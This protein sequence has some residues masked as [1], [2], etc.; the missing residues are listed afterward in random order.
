MGESKI[1]FGDKIFL[2]G[3]FMENI[4][5]FDKISYNSIMGYM[6][7]GGYYVTA[8]ETDNPIAS[9]PGFVVDISYTPDLA[10]ATPFSQMEV[11]DVTERLALS[12]P[13]PFGVKVWLPTRP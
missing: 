6:T 1:K 2:Y 13:L 5:D 11:V 9:I 7:V 10:V 4:Y 12:L 8:I 3:Q